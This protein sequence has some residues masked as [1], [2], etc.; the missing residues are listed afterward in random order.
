MDGRQVPNGHP[1]PNNAP[2]PSA[3]RRSGLRVPSVHEAL[4]YTPFSSIIPFSPELIPAP[5]AVPR[6]STAHFSDSPDIISIR[7]ALDQLSAGAANAEHASERCKQT[8]SDVQRLLDPDNLTQFKFKVP[9]RPN[10]PMRALPDGVC[11]PKLTP[12]AQMVLQTTDVSYRYLTPESPERSLPAEIHI[13]GEHEAAALPTPDAHFRHSNPSIV[14]SVVDQHVEVAKGSQSA[15]INVLNAVVIP[16]SLTPAQRA[17][18]QYMSSEQGALGDSTPSK[19]RHEHL[20]NGYRTVSVDQ[21]HKSDLAVQNL[22]NLLFEIFATEDQLQPDTSGIAAVQSNPLFTFCEV[23]GSLKQVLL[24][25]AQARLESLLQKV[26][27]N[28]RME[29][30]ATDSL[31]RVQRLCENAVAATEGISLRIDGDMS[32][33][34]VEHWL[35]RLAVAERGVVAA[36]TLLRIMGAGAYIKELQSEEYLRLTITTVHQVYETCILPIVEDRYADGDKI[37]GSKDALPANASFAF[38]M[39][40]RLSLQALLN[41]TTKTLRILGDFL[42]MVEVEETSLSS[43]EALCNRLLFAE[44]ASH[45][46]DSVFGIQSFETTRRCAM[47][48]IAK[49]FAKYPHQRQAILDSILL[50]IDKLPATRQSARHYRLQDAKPIQLVS[51]LLMR[52][53]QTSAIHEGE[54][55][56][57][58]SKSVRTTSAETDHEDNDGADSELEENED[59]AIKPTPK[60]KRN[61][62]ED[63]YPLVKPLHDAAQL[64]ASFIVR[65]LVQRALQSSKSSDEP[66]RRLLDIFT[67][68]FLAVLGSSDWPAAEMLLRTLI[69]HMV[70]I[71]EGSK[72]AVP[73]RTLALELLGT[74]GTGILELHIA[75][76]ATARSVDS[77]GNDL[78]QGLVDLVERLEIGDV[79]VGALASF[80][81]PYRTVVEYLQTR[82]LEDAQLRSAQGYH[83]M[84]WALLVCGGREVSAD[85]EYGTSKPIENLQDKL[86]SMIQ[87]LHWLE[88]HEDYPNVS[89]SQ[90]RLAAIVVT[91]SSKLCKAFNRI[92]GILLGAMSSQLPRVKSRAL[93]SVVALL[94]KDPSILDRN[95]YVLNHI[96]RCAI[97]PSPLVRDSAMSLIADCVKYR[98][99]L[100]TMLYERVIARTRDS[101][102]GVRKRA[103]RLLKDLYLSNQPVHMRAAIADAIIGRID[104]NEESIIE[105]ARQTM[106]DIWFLPFHHIK[107]NGED[108]IN[109]RLQYNAQASLLIRTTEAS[110]DSSETLQSLIKRVTSQPKLADAHTSVCRHLV[111][112]LS[113]G[114]I[115]NADIPDSP[116]QASILRCL[117]VFAKSSP[118][119]FTAGQLERLEP[120]AQNLS[121]SDDLDVYRSAITILR[122]VMPHQAALKH[123]FLQKL[124]TALLSS[125][126]KLP[127][128]E[129]SEV[130]PCLWTINGMLDNIERLA[131]FTISALKGIYSMQNVDF[132]AQPQAVVKAS[133]LMVIV[134]H[135]GKA[136]KFDERLP[137][138]KTTFSWYKGGTVAG[139]MM[140][141]VCPFTAPGQIS[142]IRQASLEAVG[143]VCQSWPELLL[144]ADVVAAL[145]TVLNE[146]NHDLEEVLLSGLA[147]FFSTG[148]APIETGGTTVPDTGIEAGQERLGNTY[149]AADKDRAAISLTRRF[150]PQIVRIA[151]SSTD[152]LSSIAARIIVS[153]NRQGLTHPKE[154]GPALVALETCPDKA[155]A[156][157]AYIEHKAQH[158][159]HESLFDKEYMRA[160]QQAFEYQ[161]DVFQDTTGH[162]SQPPVSKLHMLWDVLKAG[163]AQVR[164]KFLTSLTQKLDFKLDTL[165]VYDVQTA[166]LDFVRFSAENLAF[167]DYDKVEEL[168]L[169]LSAMEKVFS[170]T[171]TAVAQA[172]ESEVLKLHLNTVG[173]AE[174][175]CDITTE[176][177][178]AVFDTASIIPARMLQLAIAAQVCSLIWETRSYLRRLWNMQRHVAKS[179]NSGKD[180]NRAPTRVTNTSVLTDA[181]VQRV[182]EIMDANSTPE[183]QRAICSSFVELISIDSD[184]RVA[185]DDEEDREEMFQAE[186]TPSEGTSRKSPSLPASGGGRGRKRKSASTNASPRKRGRL[187]GVRRRSVSIKVDEGDEDEGW[188]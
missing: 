150:L 29:S 40:H 63:L 115:D 19:G 7:H 98:P 41:A 46:R 9:Q 137:M 158:S 99:T 139:L 55:E 179:K 53:V 132:A 140:D 172:I 141:I 157:M 112:I 134:G 173:G 51:A 27:A 164:K 73:A 175:A 75:A 102:I 18:Y 11:T 170:S 20:A 57:D 96:L 15:Q 114:I 84:Q 81:G 180:S 91:L 43:V 100:S 44:N 30:V 117:A 163:K 36:R 26:N 129:L 177:Q 59:D 187:S 128:S 79:D 138:F 152:E 169:L 149:V 92:F 135:F 154:S 90:G 136:C 151:L 94:E 184:V 110:E 42:A 1:A 101:S 130:V 133:K 86:S 52:L 111:R 47:D 89:P 16:K 178:A 107:L 28:G 14:S 10:K 119:L 33:Q 60:N 50:T 121:K 161:R 183:S 125:V 131:T 24:P 21:K 162:I 6:T 74:V 97:D 106:E 76:R 58:K 171:G 188:D 148:D 25:D 80:S 142:T 124:Q 185:S 167:F 56:L 166:H 103:I 123:D 64:N 54:A 49:D 116:D 31:V 159:K 72:S 155:I 82:D 126:S 118:K 145:E 165:D 147:T 65:L 66:Y 2:A 48:V 13:I 62:P 186:D 39:S 104:D 37:K 4:P 168:L 153:I 122:H 146:H 32:E 34:D 182:N 83:L 70:N 174:T 160:V 22:E 127:K 35:S 8:L 144:R 87:D 45:E 12:F 113:D 109:A 61:H 156:T 78:G 176:S 77:E 143:M 85:S 17:E 120:Y 93:K 68:D 88:D 108:A 181:Y 69:S 71:A 23:E 38:A 105:L 95:A 5:V 67:E 3:I